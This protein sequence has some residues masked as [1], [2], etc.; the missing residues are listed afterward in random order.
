M[1]V[2]HNKG[3]VLFRRFDEGDKVLEFKDEEVS[4][5]LIK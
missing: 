2:K 3:M 1:E 4:D 5:D